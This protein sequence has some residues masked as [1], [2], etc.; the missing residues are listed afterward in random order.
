MIY[1]FHHF[2]YWLKGGVESGQAYRMKL[3]REL[4]LEAKVVYATTFPNNS[5]EDEAEYLG[6]REGEALWMYGMFSDCKLSR[7]TYTQ[8]QFESELEG[9]DFTR[10]PA[11]K[12]CVKYSINGTGIYYMVHLM[13]PESSLVRCVEVVSDYRMIRKDYYSYCRI[14]S[15]FYTPDGPSAALSFRRFYNEDGSTAFEEMPDGKN[16]AIYRLPDRILYSRE[17]LVLEMMAR[18]S[19]TKEDVVLIDGEPGMIDMSAFL[20][21]AGP[22]RVGLVIHADHYLREREGR[23]LWYGIYEYA[24]SHSDQIDFFVTNTEAQSNLLRTQLKKY[25]GVEARVLTI[26]VVALEELKSPVSG[27]RKHALISVGRLAPEKGMDQ[28]I[29]AVVRAR[30][31][32][33]DLTLDIYGEGQLA[34]ELQSQIDR[35]GCGD[36]V[37]LCGFQ[38]LDELYAQYDAYLSASFVETFGVTYLEALGAGLPIVGYDIPYGARVFID[39]GKNGYKAPYHDVEQLA[40][41]I[42]RLFSETDVEAFRKNSYGKAQEYLSET[43]REKWKAALI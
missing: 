43:V 21:E 22:A 29:D 23:I 7:V 16:N 12:D 24:F 36:Y 19:L 30:K 4:G 2:Y 6:L 42:V 1:S 14:Y 20:Q 39:E 40:T 25:E 37:K 15:E 32:I 31:R 10:E 28:A 8:K 3:F 18:L 34:G 38:K 41:C 26:P 9:Q 13:E 33:P 11:G 17:E 35:L 27:R 5:V